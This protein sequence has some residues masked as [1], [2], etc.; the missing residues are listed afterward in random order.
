[1]SGHILFELLVIICTVKMPTIYYFRLVRLV[2]R[3]N[4]GSY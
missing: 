3:W 4:K 1:V 2:R